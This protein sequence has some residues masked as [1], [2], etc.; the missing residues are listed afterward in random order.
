M[1]YIINNSRGNIVAVIPDGSVNT[2]TSLTLIGQGVTSYGTDQNENLVYLLE[3]FA[4]PTAPSTPILGQL[5]YNSST[6]EISAYS[7]AN[8]F[9]GLTTASY[10]QAQKISPVFT[11][12]PTAPT[13]AAGTANTQIATTAFVTN[14]PVL[15]GVP[16]AP[17]AA[18]GTNTTQVAT[19]AF[20]RNATNGLG[21]MAQQNSSAVAITGGTITGLSSA[22]PVASG[23]TGGNTATAART[24]LGLGDIATQNANAVAFTSGTISGLT[25]LSFTNTTSGPVVSTGGALAAV[26]VLPVNQ[27][28]TGA[29]DAATARTNLGLGSGATATV[30]TMATQNA[31]AVAVTGGTI[32]GLSSALPVASGGTGGNTAADARSA[33]SAAASGNNS[34]ITQISGLTTALSPVFGGTGQTT[35]TA[36]AVLL[37]AGNGPIATVSPGTSGNILRSN[38]STWVSENVPDGGGTVTSVSLAGGTGISVSGSPILSA[39]TITVTNTGITSV[40]GPTGGPQTGAITFTGSGV[41]KSGN[42]YTFSST[43]ATGPQGPAGPAGANGT[44][45]TNGT[46]GINGAQGP[47]GP[48]GPQGPQGTPGSGG[49]VYLANNQ[50]FTG[51]NGFSATVTLSNVVRVNNDNE[52]GAANSGF[53]NFGNPGGWSMGKSVYSSITCLALKAG[54]SGALYISGSDTYLVSNRFITSG[55]G[56]FQTSTDSALYGFCNGTTGAAGVVGTYSQANPGLGI[57]VSAQ[58]S[59][60]GFGGDLVQASTPRSSSTAFDF[61]EGIAAGASIWKVRGNGQFLTSYSGADYAEYF[62]SATGSALEVG[63]TVVLDN[64][65]VR[66]TTAS[67]AV[68]DI[69]GVV[70]PKDEGRTTAMIGN[71]SELQWNQRWITDDFGRFIKDTHEIV[72]WQTV[73]DTGMTKYHSYESHA[74]PTGVTVPGHAVNQSHD[75]D[76][77][78]YY[79]Y[80]ENPA[81]NPDA[82]Y[83]PRSQRDEWVIVGMVGQVPV[84]KGQPVNPAW[85]RMKDI[86]SAVELW[87]I[88]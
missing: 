83:V 7:T 16:T 29:S 79:H 45:G 57:G 34:D 59:S 72:E 74:V 32:T 30:G 10:V 80:R 70:R 27:G 61:I 75:T 25:S 51:T 37:G 46:N 40:T 33:L 22:L 77:N 42:V 5:W 84:L 56:V 15:S 23:G 18:N 68:E 81:Y 88:R 53:I 58:G 44:N 87:F 50:V 11:G 35:F 4:S 39:G 38:G 54:T 19:T 31:N 62:E 60:S 14:S 55:T 78:A 21:T 3:N 1:S 36:G 71:E 63:A 67:D 8:T 65:L 9:V 48:Q 73:D 47:E 64:G 43:G 86:S 69:I 6:D 20:V 49:D 12:V 82:T 17:T 66:V 76:G 28:G 85:R 2:S 52:G 26:A 41:T 24:N 13:A